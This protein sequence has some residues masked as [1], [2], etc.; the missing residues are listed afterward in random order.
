M[1]L[2]YFGLREEP[3][4]VTPDPRF[5][6]LGLSH[7][8]A[9]ASLLHGINTGR[10]FMALIA[11]AGMGKTTLL[12]E[13]L[14]QTRSYARSVSLF[15]TQC[16]RLELLRYML[17]DSGL[18]ARGDDVVVMHE[19]FNDLLLRNDQAGKKF[20]V[21]I[22]EAQNLSEEV[23]E[24]IRLLSDFETPERKLLQI[25]LAG[26]PHFGKTLSRPEQSQLRQRMSIVC[27][28]SALD[29][30][31]VQEYIETRLRI[32]GRTGPLFTERAL[33]AVTE[34]SYGIPR[35][36]NNYCFN[37]L[38]LACATQ[39]P[40]VDESMVDEV[41][42]DLEIES[43]AGEMSVPENKTWLDPESENAV[44]GVDR[45]DNFS[46]AHRVSED[47]PLAATARAYAARHESADA[48]VPIVPEHQR[49]SDDVI[50]EPAGDFWQPE[51]PLE[52]SIRYN[53]PD[54][55]HE[56]RLE[57]QF[58]ADAPVPARTKK[59]AILQSVF[60]ALAVF[61]LFVFASL[62][63]LRLREEPINAE[64]ALAGSS[65]PAGREGNSLN[66]TSSKKKKVASPGRLNRRTSERTSLANNDVINAP[67]PSGR[68]DLLPLE[69]VNQP[70]A[71][72]EP[73]APL[74]V[75]SA[76]GRADEGRSSTFA[77]AF[78]SPLA[79][80]NVVAESATTPPNTGSQNAGVFVPGQ[81]IS[82]VMPEFPSS[83]HPVGGAVEL[84]ASINE[85]GEVEHVQI[86]NGLGILSQAA[87]TAVRR[88]RYTPF[89]LDGKPVKATTHISIKF[90]PVGD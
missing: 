45:S 69:S 46:S 26:Q 81:L 10:G 21:V 48:P 50:P 88:W 30:R 76:P 6:Y 56:L 31:E 49:G 20:V 38:S 47:V 27:R 55:V 52:P 73:A 2:R 85:R 36:I 74:V 80:A 22:D 9:L 59:K 41:T 4:G 65:L 79:A 78:S 24:S 70:T 17:T 1:Y 15:Q 72:P 16:S 68:A 61:V 84:T 51:R 13:V 12:N 39:Q 77:V 57:H 71:T 43:R 40:M 14:E 67:V 19:Q 82:K 83:A 86:E 37:L 62:V 8:E 23:L 54:I 28:L 64:R 63:S 87:A 35:I 90:K 75:G 11:G 89:T 42:M 44:V 34:R 18:E 58:R 60:L 29:R 32:A 66:K 33:D 5:L 25:V 3:F 7:R 53:E